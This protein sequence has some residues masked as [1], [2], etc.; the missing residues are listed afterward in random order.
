MSSVSGSSIPPSDISTKRTIATSVKS[1]T[2]KRAKLKTSTSVIDEYGYMT[3]QEETF[4]IKAYAVCEE[5]NFKEMH[6][7][8]ISQGLYIPTVV[9]E[10]ITFLNNP[11]TN[12]C[13]P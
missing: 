1:A 2:K 5:F 6:K 8:L 9:S 3:D 11:C 4:P 12:F 10:G 7:G 13:G